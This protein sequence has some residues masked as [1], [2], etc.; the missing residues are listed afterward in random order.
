HPASVPRTAGGYA[1]HAE[2]RG[3]CFLPKI[4]DLTG[5]QR[6]RGRPTDDRKTCVLIIGGGRRTT[7]WDYHRPRSAQPGGCTRAG[8]IHTS[9]PHHE[10]I[11]LLCGKKCVCF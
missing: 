3:Y 2:N 1:N 5:R 11:A 7:H 10:P 9:A 4:R 8:Y 6:R